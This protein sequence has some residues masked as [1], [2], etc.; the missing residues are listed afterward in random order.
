MLRL[1]KSFDKYHV[2]IRAW[3]KTFNSGNGLVQP[4]Y[5][6]FSTTCSG[7][8]YLYIRNMATIQEVQEGR[9]KRWYF[10]LSW[11]LHLAAGQS[12]WVRW[13]LPIKEMVQFW[14]GRRYKICRYEFSHRS[15]RMW[16]KNRSP[17][18]TPVLSFL[19]FWKGDFIRLSLWWGPN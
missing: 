13:S 3:S 12:W 8:R 15:R 14:P 4:L 9:P 19:G 10:G 18:P 1:D 5:S 16:R 11:R 6:F 2:W 7:E 17:S